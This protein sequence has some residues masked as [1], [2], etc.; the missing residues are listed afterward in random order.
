MFI[1]KSSSFLALVLASIVAAQSTCC[2]NGIFT[3]DIN[4]A[5]SAS[6]PTLGQGQCYKGYQ[7][8]CEEIE[9]QDQTNAAEFE[10]TVGVEG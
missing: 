1:I 8:I 4:T 9:Y 2:P 3:G 6:N 5:C 7:I 10:I